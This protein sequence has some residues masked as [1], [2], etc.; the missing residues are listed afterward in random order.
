MAL[1]EWKDEY[2]VSVKRFDGEHKKLFSLLN[3]LNEAMTRGQGR[4]VISKVLQEL[5]TYTRVHFAA[6]ESAMRMV[7]FS[8][9]PS[10]TA[11]HRLLTE[12]VEQFAADF[13]KGNACITIDVL[14]FLRDWLQNHIL[15]TDRKYREALQEMGIR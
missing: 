3:E 13:S 12:K 4:L 2:S 8:G 14:Y 6:E 1:F 15:A 7:A 5:L 10:H 11:E 9:L